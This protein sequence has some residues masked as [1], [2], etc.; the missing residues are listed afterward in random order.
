MQTKPKTYLYLCI[1]VTL[2]IV[3]PLSSQILAPKLEST[4]SEVESSD[5]TSNPIPDESI[6]I[7]NASQYNVSEYSI[8]LGNKTGLRV[9]EENATMEVPNNWDVT[10]L[11]LEVPTVYETQEIFSEHNLNG[12]FTGTSDPWDN[13]TTYP[14]RG[15]DSMSYVDFEY[16]DEDEWAIGT[17]NSGE[18]GYLPDY[19]G[20]VNTSVI[21]YNRAGSNLEIGE[22]YRDETS[23]YPGDMFGKPINNQFFDNPKWEVLIDPYGGYKGSSE[24]TAEW[25]AGI[26]A[27]RHTIDSKWSLQYGYGQPSI[28]YGTP[29]YIPFEA[30]SVSITYRYRVEN[31]GY[32]ILD[33]M[34]IVSLIDQQQVNGSIGVNG[35]DYSYDTG[36]EAL[37]EY[38]G[39]NLSTGYV[40]HVESHD[41][42][43]RTFNITDLLGPYGYR[44]GYH[45]LDFGVF[46]VNPDQGNDDVIVEWD[47]ISINASH[48]EWNKAARLEF[49]FTWKELDKGMYGE[50][51]GSLALGLY[52]GGDYKL[53]NISRVFLAYTGALV[54][55][56][57]YHVDMTLPH[58]YKDAFEVDDFYFYIGLEWAGPLVGDPEFTRFQ[59]SEIIIDNFRLTVNYNLGSPEAL[60]LEMRLNDGGGWMDVNSTNII[61]TLITDP[62]LEIEFNIS[63][64]SDPYI[65]YYAYAQC[66]KYS[67]DMAFSSVDINRF[68]DEYA[69]WNT[70]YNNT[71]SLNETMAVNSSSANFLYYW[72]KIENL[73]AFDGLGE[74]STDWNFFQVEAPARIDVTSHM[75]RESDDPFLQNVTVAFFVWGEDISLIKGEWHFYAVQENYMTNGD[76]YLSGGVESEKFYHSNASEYQ[77]EVRNF[78]GQT[79]SYQVNMYNTSYNL[80]Q[81]FP[82]YHDNVVENQ[83]YSWTVNDEGVGVY[84]LYSTW[85]DTNAYNQTQRFG[86]NFDAFSIWRKIQHSIAEGA[87]GV[88]VTSGDLAVYNIQVNL[89]VL[90]EPGVEGA[91]FN[92]FN[93]GTGT[94]WGADW[95]PYTYLL[96]GFTDNGLGSYTIYLK[97]VNV[98]LGSYNIHFT[99]HMG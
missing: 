51:S 65:R 18:T 39:V 63:G 15:D 34:A 99:I 43:E 89:T 96:H 41:Y 11:T 85:N 84:F 95:P 26:D 30:D 56:Y 97:T 21:D 33:T 6:G 50:D 78:T 68:S 76:L 48:Y 28:A 92:A 49:D 79:G 5:T 17:F 29:F 54:S 42:Y 57:N 38:D 16:D 74:L 91:G 81:N 87:G 25:V 62:N 23:I 3:L 90:G 58:L 69:L 59:K 86:W 31:L 80:T 19:I 12:N 14:F 32:D 52:L 10:G 35:E 53:D 60:G 1:S 61:S 13:T 75:S 9:G 88:S 46:L 40:G 47:Y 73:P 2:L 83:T 67:E 82:Q 72:L 27:L 45:Y 70:T 37:L 93:N 36:N 55:E 22:K 7:Y 77:L 64:V 8:F 71:D 20:G 66:H 4:F 44:T 24:V 98:P 94:I